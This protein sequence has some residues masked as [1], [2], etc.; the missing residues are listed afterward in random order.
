[1]FGDIWRR[2]QQPEVERFQTVG[3][4]MSTDQKLTSQQSW[5]AAKRWELLA[6]RGAIRTFSF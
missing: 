2:F 1:M 4:T 6:I 5:K 3:S